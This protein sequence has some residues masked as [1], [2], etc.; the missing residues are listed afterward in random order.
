[1]NLQELDA[2]L[3]RFMF[4]LLAK[5]TNGDYPEQEY[6]SDRRII[7]ANNELKKLLP[8]DI[9]E[10]YTAAGFRT[11]MQDK[12][13]Y[14]ERRA[15]INEALKPALEYMEAL[16]NKDDSFSLNEDSYELGAQLGYGG[17]GAVYKYHHMLLNM[18]FA[19]KIF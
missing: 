18:D 9:S 4:G 8:A 11:Y 6:A 19:I 15:F 10:H 1:M 2:T 13:G 7:F 16:V 5:A 3:K 17:F 14:V 12:G